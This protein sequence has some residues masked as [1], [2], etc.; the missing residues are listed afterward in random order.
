MPTEPRAEMG[1]LCQQNVLMDGS[2]LSQDI[3]ATSKK[4]YNLPPCS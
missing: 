1:Q 4:L 3:L 2:Q